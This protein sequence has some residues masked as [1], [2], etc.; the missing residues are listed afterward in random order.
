MKEEIILSPMSISRGLLGILSILFIAYLI[1]FDRKHINWKLVGKGLILELVFVLC[2]FYVPIVSTVIETCGSFFVKTLSFTEEGVKF[3]LGPYAMKQNGFSFLFHSLP[4]LIFFSALISLLYYWGVIQ[5][6]VSGFSWVI[7]RILPINGVEG[8]VVSG[9]IFLG[10]TESPVLIKN[11]LPKMNRSELFIVLVSGMGTIAGTVMGTYISMLGQESSAE[12]ILFAK[13]LLSASLLAAPG[14]IIL[15]KMICPQTEAS[16]CMISPE[17]ISK[18][19]KQGSFL[20]AITDGMSIGLKLMANIAGMLLVFIALIALMNYLTKD[21]IGEYTGLNQ[22]ITDFTDGDSTGLTIEF[23]IGLIFS[24]L[25]WLIGVPS[26]D[27]L[28]VGSLLGQKTILN[29]FVA[30]LQLGE[31]KELG[32]FKHSK[33]IIMSTYLLCGFANL[34]SIGILM[35]GISILAPEKRS[36]VAS[37][38]LRA[39]LAGALVSVLSATIIGMFF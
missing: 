24:P 4:N 39:M 5:R 9:N 33:S 32:F 30:Y 17:T 28:L 22:W 37:H 27:M 18:E 16:N 15:A 34:S 10:M 8:L 38:G 2:I 13:H 29:E 35:G 7:R 11:Y 31:W 3:L 21:I 6:I 1:S 23:M 19:N 36:F 26:E 25:M 14:S 12:N 20:D